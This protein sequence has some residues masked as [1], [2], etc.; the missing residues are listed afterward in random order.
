MATVSFDTKFEVQ[1]QYATSFFDAWEK[2]IQNPRPVPIS[3]YV[4][5]EAE[6]RGE[7]LLKRICSR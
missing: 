2:N 5:K 7:E 4:S 3:P 6:E 1:E